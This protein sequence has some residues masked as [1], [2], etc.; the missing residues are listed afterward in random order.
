MKKLLFLSLSLLTFVS[1]V[2][3][4]SHWDFD[5]ANVDEFNYDMSTIIYSD[6]VLDGVTTN[7]QDVLSAYEVAAF[8]D[9]EVRAKGKVYTYTPAGSSET[10]YLLRFNVWGTISDQDKSITFKAFHNNIEYDLEM[11]EE[12]LPIFTGETLDPGAPSNP[13]HLYL[14]VISSISVK[15]I[16]LNVGEQVELKDYLQLTP[17]DATMPNNIGWAYGSGGDD[18]YGIKTGTT[19]KAINPNTEGAS[20]WAIVGDMDAE[21]KVYIYQPATSFTCIQE[22]LTVYVGDKFRTQ[23][24]ATYELLPANTTDYVSWDFDESTDVISY[25]SADG[26]YNALAV[27]DVVLT[28]N[29]VTGKGRSELSPI[30]VTVHVKQHVTEITSRFMREPI[31]CSV[32]DVLTSYFVDGQAFDVGPYNASNKDV[33]FSLTPGYAD[34]GVLSCVD[35]VIKALQKGA[36]AIRVTSVDNPLVYC[37]VMVQVYYDVQTISANEEVVTVKRG[38]ANLNISDLLTNNLTSGPE[39]A[40]EFYNGV[41]V[42]ATPAGIVTISDVVAESGLVSI[43]AT[44]DAAGTATITVNYEVKDYLTATFNPDAVTVT[45]KVATFTVEV[46]Q[47]VTNI[48]TRFEREQLE[49][50][51]GDDLTPYLVDGTAFAVIPDNAANK[52]VT[53]SIAAGADN[54]ILTIDADGNIKAVKGGQ[55]MVTVTSVDDPTVSRNLRVQV[56]NDAKT[57]DI[58]SQNVSVLYT[59]EEGQLANAA[60]ADNVVF[61]PEGA[62][63]IYGYKPSVTSSNEAVIKIGDIANSAGEPL[64]VDCEVRVM[65]A[66]EADITVAIQVKD[67]LKATFDDAN[68]YVTTVSKTFKVIVTQGVNGFE[69]NIPALVQF[70]P[71]T[72][73]ITP[74]PANAEIDL[75]KLTIT[76]AYQGNNSW[77]GATVGNVAEGSSNTFTSSVQPLIPGFVTFTVTY[78]NGTAEPVTITSD[79][80]EVGYTMSMPNNWTWK[81]VPYGY[82]ETDGLK[83]VFGDNLV[84][85]RTQSEQLYNDPEYGYFG[86][87]DLL[88]QNKCFKLKMNVSSTRSYVFYGGQLGEMTT[89]TLRKGWNWIPNPYIFGRTFDSAFSGMTFQEGDRIIGKDGFAEYNGTAWSGS[90]QGLNKGEGYLF[91]NAGAA[92]RTLT[93]A[94]ELSMD[95]ADELDHEGSAPGPQ[96]ARMHTPEQPSLFSYDANRFRDNMTIVAELQ[97]VA[98]ADYYQAFAFVGDEC[99]GRGISQDGKLFIT[100]HA[101]TGEQVSFKLY[102]EL[103]GE[104]ADAEQTVSM[105]QMLG[106]INAPFMMTSNAITTGISNVERLTLNVQSYDLGGR[107]VNVRQNGVQLQRQPNGMVRKVIK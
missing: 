82:P 26:E 30:Q 38:S 13:R 64:T 59:G 6:L 44:A 20:I 17:A 41:S 73:T 34:T 98:D 43:S 54:S 71:A 106:T 12:P 23:L 10:M 84:E 47:G 97:D 61:G 45:Q 60:V 89:V 48:N 1:G 39:Y 3:A 25:T 70:R 88:T 31:E 51:V 46:T 14:T 69:L 83:T 57:I 79:P 93:Y 87:T 27:G 21:G 49:C 77:K 107:R 96:G 95:D 5:D 4:Q 92:G 40:Q 24:D 80:A 32:G 105:Q 36:A 37:D 63:A 33:T 19:I 81:T 28:G 104:L 16:I 55:T 53:F 101:E 58:L 50:S 91:W 100:V 102:N 52:N 72:V 75:S 29:I 11:R 76:A 90:L 42:T 35:G 99:R 103:T 8:I 2:R 18:Y 78:D 15:D 56:Y 94:D 66:G 68:D 7:N 9:D 62:D 85:I 74:I 22:E 65:G 86:D 67:Y